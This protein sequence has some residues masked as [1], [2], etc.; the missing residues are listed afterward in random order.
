MQ[1]SVF[2]P[3]PLG[4][5]PVGTAAQVVEIQGGRELLRKLRALGVRVG[6]EVRVE[7]HR[8]RGLVLSVGAARVALG[9]GIVEKL[10][11]VPL[12][13]PYDRTGDA[14]R[15]APEDSTAGVSRNPPAT[16]PIG[17]AD[18]PSR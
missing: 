8:G 4:A 9:G 5:L 3:I 2:K 13:S 16:A 18:Q 11:V 7:H 17:A 1:Q 12:I 14:T 10:L 6:S 15:D